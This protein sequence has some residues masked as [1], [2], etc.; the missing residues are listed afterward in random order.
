MHQIR[1][2]LACVKAHIVSDMTYGGKYTYL[3]DIK[4]K[5]N[6]KKY[7]EEQP[8]MQRVALHAHTLSFKGVNGEDIS[9]SAPYPKDMRALV[10]QL[11]K[12]R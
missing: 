2:H 1:I 5:I 8:L 12:N 6:L 3:S 7:E 11:S 4:R 9:V 10:N